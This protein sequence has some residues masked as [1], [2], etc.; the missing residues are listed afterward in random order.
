MA[1]GVRKLSFVLGLLLSVLLWASLP[2]THH[3]RAVGALRAPDTMETATA[4]SP[5][6]HSGNR[7][8]QSPDS[9]QARR[10]PERVRTSIQPSEANAWD[11]LEDLT[12]MAE[13]GDVAADEDQFADNLTRL[14]QMGE[15]ALVAIADF[16]LSP[17]GHGIDQGE[18]RRALLNVLLGLG[19]PEVEDV[20]LQLLS[21]NPQP[22][23]IWQLG[24]YLE[25]LRPGKYTD[26]IRTVAEQSLVAAGDTGNIP[27]ELF[28]LLGEVGDEGT[29]ELLAQMPAHR[30]AYA[31]SALALISDGSGLPL[32]EQDARSLETG[33]STAQG[34][35]ALELLAQQSH[36]YPEA[37]D[38]LIDLSRKGSIPA[39]M[40]PLILSLSMGR[41]QITLA[42]P[43]GKLVS[44]KI[45]YSPEGNQIVYLAG[46]TPETESLA[47]IDQRLE[48]LWQL[49]QVAPKALIPGIISAQD[50]LIRW[51]RNMSA[52][53][54]ET[55]A[56]GAGHTGPGSN[57]LLI[58]RSATI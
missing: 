13:A 42:P 45:I 31:S 40:W 10:T 48:T 37:L 54:V 34:R 38:T 21:G 49:Q 44:W 29:A 16:L 30:E 51:Q 39:D 41:Q 19:L 12:W 2:P 9:Q 52:S 17:E 11:I 1:V 47:T 3:T 8:R 58:W 35:F 28:Q 20:A 57:S 27:G 24:R 36:I 33:Q 5:V 6:D 43:A 55:S 7:G 14:G 32:L 18:L 23:E 56:V 50:Q 53:A 15:S 22:I 46:R 26:S 25:D 4:G